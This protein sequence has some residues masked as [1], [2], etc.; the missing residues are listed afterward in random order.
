MTMDDLQP[1]FQLLKVALWGKNNGPFELI[2][3]YTFLC[4]SC[5]HCLM[6][7]MMTW[8][9]A[10]YIEGCRMYT[11]LS[12]YFRHC[13]TTLLP[14]ALLQQVETFSA[15]FRE[16]CIP[17]VIQD[18]LEKINIT[19]SMPININQYPGINKKNAQLLMF[20]VFALYSTVDAFSN[21]L[22]SCP[23]RTKI[24][25][26]AFILFSPLTCHTIL[27]FPAIT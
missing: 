6:R 13:S 26:S 25:Y 27:M 21:V 19:G 18:W 3:C 22:Q 17:F 4:M 16:C 7:S 14:S 15:C 11:Q 1:V 9:Q 2:M 5:G 23:T 24:D 8:H 12:K 10:V 20:R